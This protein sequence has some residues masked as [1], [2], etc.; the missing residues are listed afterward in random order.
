MTMKEATL[1]LMDQQDQLTFTLQQSITYN[2][3]HQIIFHIK[4]AVLMLIIIPLVPSIIQKD[5]K[6]VS[7][8]LVAPCLYQTEVCYAYI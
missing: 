6:A 3:Y 7:M 4:H 5:Q 2:I 8:E 1:P